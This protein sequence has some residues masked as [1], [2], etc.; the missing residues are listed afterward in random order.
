MLSKNI[1]LI[2]S[3]L[4][5]PFGFVLIVMGYDKMSDSEYYI[6]DISHGFLLSL[7]WTILGG[8]IFY[9][10]LLWFSAHMLSFVP[11]IGWNSLFSTVDYYLFHYFFNGGLIFMSANLYLNLCECEEGF[12]G[13]EC[14]PCPQ[15]NG[16][17]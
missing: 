5:I 12:Y 1:F 10:W 13:P 15:M 17:I 9:Q 4:S 8:S 6:Q 11:T 7:G 16:Q 14:L 2:L 3:L